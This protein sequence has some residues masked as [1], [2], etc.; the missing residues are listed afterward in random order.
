MLANAALTVAATRS[1]DAGVSYPVEAGPDWS[2]LAAGLGALLLVVVAIG[3][4][5]AVALRALR[6][7]D[8][9]EEA[10]ASRTHSIINIW[11]N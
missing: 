6:A 2:A 11:K 7:H 10:S 8:R 5:A 3:I 9:G 1:N 4:V